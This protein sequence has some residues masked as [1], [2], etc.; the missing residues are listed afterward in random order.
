MKHKGRVK[1]VVPVTSAMQR[2]GPQLLFNWGWGW[3]GGLGGKWGAVVLFAKGKVKDFL[4]LSLLGLNLFVQRCLCG[5]EPLL[6]T[7]AGSSAGLAGSCLQPMHEASSERCSPSATIT[8]PFPRVQDPVG[9]TTIDF[10]CR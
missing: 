2:D 3:G 10:L 4:S 5:K 6:G 9:K 8:W 7:A 1:G